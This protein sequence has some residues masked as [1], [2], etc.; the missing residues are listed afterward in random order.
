MFNFFNSIIIYNVCINFCINSIIIIYLEFRFVLTQITLTKQWKIIFFHYF[1]LLQPNACIAVSVLHQQSATPSTYPNHHLI[2]PNSIPFHI[3]AL[4]LPQIEN[5]IKE[6]L[7]IEWSIFFFLFLFLLHIV[8]G[9]NGG[10]KTN[11]HYIVTVQLPTATKI[12]VVYFPT[13]TKPM[14]FSHNWCFSGDLNCHNN[15]H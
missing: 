9:P 15:Y 11:H 2:P 7:S 6:P 13:A 3:L 5:P 8:V 14:V 10:L 12:V 1:L 4:S